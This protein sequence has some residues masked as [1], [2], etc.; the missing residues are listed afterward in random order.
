MPDDR[1]ARLFD[2][3]PASWR[4]AHG[5][6]SLCDQVLAAY[7]PSLTVREIATKA[8]VSVPTAYVHLRGY[9]V[10]RSCGRSECLR[11]FD[12]VLRVVDERLA[13]ASWVALSRAYGYDPHQPHVLQRSI[14]M[15]LDRTDRTDLLGKLYPRGAPP[16]LERWRRRTRAVR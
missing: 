1:A 4:R 13:G 16:W 7:D 9:S 10:A 5:R 15:R 14:F 11:T 12:E 6:K 2:L 8:G 3:D